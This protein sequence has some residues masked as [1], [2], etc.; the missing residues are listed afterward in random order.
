MLRLA[1]VY[2]TE[3][4]SLLFPSK[5]VWVGNVEWITGAKVS[6]EKLTESDPTDPSAF[7]ANTLTEWSPSLKVVVGNKKSYVVWQ[8]FSQTVTDEPPFNW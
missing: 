4:G 5:Y 6:T 8:L 3:N 1:S 7:C 2:V